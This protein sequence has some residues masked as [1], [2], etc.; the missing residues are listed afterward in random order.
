MMNK[1]FTTRKR[2][3]PRLDVEVAAIPRLN[4]DEVMH[5]GAEDSPYP[6]HVGKAVERLYQYEE[7][8][9]TPEE[10]RSLILAAKGLEGL[11]DKLL[12]RRDFHRDIRAV[13]D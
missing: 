7:L 1:R 4:G 13:I 5:A 9:Y 3:E 12:D 6:Y 10:L 8:G 11:N 2:F